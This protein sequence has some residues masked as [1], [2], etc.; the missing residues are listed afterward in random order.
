MLPHSQHVEGC[1]NCGR[2]YLELGS[3]EIALQ[4]FEQA[5]AID[6]QLVEA[7]DKKAETLRKLKRY[8]E[9]I[10]AQKKTV[11][12][13]TNNIRE[14][15]D[16]SP[17]FK[18]GNQQ[19]IMINNSR[20]V[21][22]SCNLAH[23]RADY[24][25]TWNDGGYAL[26]NSGRNEE[27]VASYDTALR[28]K[29]DHYDAWNGR[30]NAL[31]D[32]G[33]H[34]EAIVSYDTALRH[35]PDCHH[36]W[37][38]RG[39]ALWD[40]GQHEEAI[41][42]YD[43]ALR[44]KPDYH[45]PWN[46]RGNA[47]W[48]LGRYEEAIVSYDTAL[49]YK[50]DYHY[51]WNGRGNA[52]GDLGRYEEAI[53]SYD[54]ALRYKP[55]YHYAWNG[56][57]YAAVN[58]SERRKMSLKAALPLVMQNPDLN[59]RGYEGQ[60][61][62]IQ[63]GFKCIAQGTEGWGLLHYY[64]GAAHSCQARKVESPRPFWRKAEASYKTALMTLTVQQFPKAHLN[65]LQDLISILY[66]LREIDEAKTI[67]RDGSDLICRLL[68]DPSCSTDHQKFLQS[69]QSYFNQITVDLAIQSKSEIEAL[70]LAEHGKNTCLRWM[71]GIDEVPPIT[72]QQIQQWLSPVAAIVY[73]HLSP[74]TLTTFVILPECPEP[75][76]I[77]GTPTQLADWEKWLF[78]WNEEYE[79][80]STKKDVTQNGHSWRIKMKERLAA[81]KIILKISAIR[82]LLED[83]SLNQ[84]ILVPHRDLHRF[85]LHSFFDLPCSY[86]PSIHFGLIAQPKPLN[87]HRLLLV[88]NPKNEAVSFGG[89][90][91]IE[92]ESALIQHLYPTQVIESKNATS[93]I[94][95]SALS[96]PFQSFH[97]TG[98]AA[99]NS[100]NPAQSCLFLSGTDRLTLRTL[101]HLDLS[102]Y[103]LIC[104]AACE[105]GIT[106]KQTIT[107]EYV[108]LP[109]AFLK[110]KATRIVS[111]FWRVESAASTFFIVEFY[112][113]LQ[114]GNPPAISL[115]HAQTFLKT[116]TRHDLITWIEAALP[117][118]SK[119]CQIALRCER[120]QIADSL[121]E[122]PYAH[123]YYWTAF[124]IAGL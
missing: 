55:D 87:L 119:A 15:A 93:T 114:A 41:V 13:L 90:T 20:E 52:L 80:Y 86:L 124:S 62:S 3:Y 61:A 18:Q 104:L 121:I 65:T 111:T 11:E 46:G 22:E 70:E 1:L 99:Y 66:A 106:G 39:N 34:E 64:L 112:R 21:I 31:H 5:I 79:S 96:Q 4:W 100:Q 19:K 7:W 97:F 54:T 23:R 49:R 57:G 45:H 77:P 29:P 115:Q 74:S 16:T 28:Y 38:G 101:A 47:L 85:P 107:D 78:N 122:H 98:H 43:T 113:S 32:L 120:Q 69:K 82:N 118:L 2:Y 84:L 51:A 24:A 81:L 103:D 108:G 33:R 6:P 14:S 83:N 36:P 30:G 102:S 10:E 59:K 37:N 42:S 105:T 26:W 63:E 88:E 123:P 48:D 73:W 95:D 67:Q 27:A 40:L 76:V 17:W 53:V 92:I 117:N 109:S 75:I 91:F 71:L 8:E 58:S 89:G 110:A 60:L 72:Y 116:A 68:S 25:E 44:Y 56:R 50:P 94:V 12:I 9:A 35:K